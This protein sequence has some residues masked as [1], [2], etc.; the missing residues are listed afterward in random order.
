MYVK[1]YYLCQQEIFTK[2]RLNVFII[3]CY[4]VNIKLKKVSCN[5]IDRYNVL[6]LDQVT[7]IHDI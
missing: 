2:V 3:M 6:Y 5:K 4:K 7:K 1:S